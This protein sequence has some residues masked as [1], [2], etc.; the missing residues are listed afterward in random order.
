MI[1]AKGR[2]T[3]KRV[4]T[5]PRVYSVQDISL[6][7]E[8]HSE[9]V[10][11]RP[12]DLSRRGMFISTSRTFPEGAV[13]NLRFRLAVTGTEIRT[14]C[15]VRHCLAGVGVGVEFVGLSPKAANQIDEEIKVCEQRL[16]QKRSRQKKPSDLARIAKRSRK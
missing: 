7:Y 14:R 12:P 16:N 15:E 8:G 2:K 3:W 10:R 13:L 4:R 5:N 1:S 6:T 9:E 11:V